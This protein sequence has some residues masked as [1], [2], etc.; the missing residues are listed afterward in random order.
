REI[1]ALLQTTLLAGLGVALYAIPE[2]LG[3]SPS[4]VLITGEFSV[5][6]W[7]QDVQTRVFATFG[8]PNWLAA[9]F[10]LLIPLL[11]FFLLQELQGKNFRPAWAGF[12]LFQL[13]CFTLAFLFTDSRSGFLGIVLE[14]A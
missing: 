7:V 3:V 4:C 11:P 10:L 8:Q 14:L 12:W 1:V 6:C 9:Y 5:H 2:R 13:L